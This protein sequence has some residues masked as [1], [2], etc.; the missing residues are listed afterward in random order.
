MMVGL[1]FA[2]EMETLNAG[3]PCTRSEQASMYSVLSVLLLLGIEWESSQLLEFRAVLRLWVNIF[4][5]FGGN[6]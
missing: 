5:S 1:L 2:Q 3:V 6:C 4:F